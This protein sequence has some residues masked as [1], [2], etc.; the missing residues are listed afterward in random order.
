MLIDKVTVMSLPS[1]IYFQCCRRHGLDV[2]C[3]VYVNV[4]ITRILPC[5]LTNALG[6]TK[7]TQKHMPSTMKPHVMTMLSFPQDGVLAMTIDM[8]DIM[9]SLHRMYIWHSVHLLQHL[10]STLLLYFI[11]LLAIFMC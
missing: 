6:T 5:L 1:T 10:Q 8:V 7:I 3:A 2:I 11:T 4:K 9:T